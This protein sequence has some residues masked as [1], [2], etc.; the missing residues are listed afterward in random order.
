MV[1]QLMLLACLRRGHRFPF[2]LILV[3]VES[4]AFF[5]IDYKY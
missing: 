1:V 5:V 2:I 3:L 4:T